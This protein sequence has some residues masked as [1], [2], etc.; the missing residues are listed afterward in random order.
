MKTDQK[1]TK[2]HLMTKPQVA[3]M[4]SISVPTIYRMIDPSS[5]SYVPDFPLP[6]KVGERNLRFRS[7]EIFL[8]IKSR[9]RGTYDTMRGD[10]E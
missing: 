4:L 9:E 6:I 7:D 1:S 5:S 3:E 8:W 10:Y 2:F